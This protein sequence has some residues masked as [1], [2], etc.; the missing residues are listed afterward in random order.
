[1]S[2]IRPIT[3]SFV[4]P[5]LR[6]ATTPTCPR[7]TLPVITKRFAQQDYGSGAGDPK[8]ENPKAQG[9]APQSEK[10]E[11]PGPP[12]PAE[13]QGSGSTP[14]KGGAQQ[15]N[16]SQ[17]ASPSSGS[18]SSSGGGGADKKSGA[19]PKIL[20]PS[21]HEGKPGDDRTSSDEVARHNA[22][23]EKRAEKT[24]QVENHDGQEKD[25]VGKQFWSGRSILSYW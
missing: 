12:P 2:P 24:G 25:K 5:F 20:D 19:Q 11:H 14:T 4:R 17:S 6:S 7:S 15:S 22:D 9:S 10:L 18:S 21:S 23:V 1:M 3:T 13:G 8:G 16:G